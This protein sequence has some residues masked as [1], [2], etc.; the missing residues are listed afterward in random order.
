[1]DG[2]P[3]RGRRAGQSGPDPVGRLG[4]D[5]QGAGEE[6][7]G[8]EGEGAEVELSPEAAARLAYEEKLAKVL[9]LARNNPKVISNLIKEWMGSNEQ[10]R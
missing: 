10:Q 5:R 3:D 4:R 1:M 8:E 2:H 6:G 7:E 9:A